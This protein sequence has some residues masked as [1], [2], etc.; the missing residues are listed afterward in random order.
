MNVTKRVKS[1]TFSFSL[2]TAREM[3]HLFYILC[4]YIMFV[5]EFIHS[6]VKKVISKFIFKVNDISRYWDDSSEQ[7]EEEKSICSRVLCH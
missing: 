1:E 6:R 7:K 2:Q 3:R 4:L 5:Q